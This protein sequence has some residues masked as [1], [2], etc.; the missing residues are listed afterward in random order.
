MVQ[1]TMLVIFASLA[2]STNNTAVDYLL[3]VFYFLSLAFYFFNQCH[4][5]LP[6][7]RNKYSQFLTFLLKVIGPIFVVFPKNNQFVFLIYAFVFIL[8]ETI[9]TTENKDKNSQNRLLIYKFLFLLTYAA[10]FMYTILEN[11]VQVET[12]SKVIGVVTLIALGCF[13]LAF[14]ME[15]FIQVQTQFCD[16]K[17]KSKPTAVN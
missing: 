6:I 12:L 14:I 3:A 8:F 4:Y 15:A 1:E 5:P 16:P 9:V 2:Y 11:F 10:I 17:K 13:V 7:F